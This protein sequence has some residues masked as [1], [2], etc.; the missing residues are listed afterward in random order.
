MT[1]PHKNTPQLICIA[2]GPGS[3]KSYFY[4]SLKSRGEIPTD[5]VIHDPDLIMEAMP[6]YQKDAK[7]DPAKAFERW[8]LPARQRANEILIEA[9]NARYTIVY[10]RSFALP[11]SLEFIQHAKQLGY[12]IT[13]NIL[14]CDL[15]TAIRRVKNRER[16]LSIET[17]VQRHEAVEVILPELMR[18]ADKYYFYENNIDNSEPVLIEFH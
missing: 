7:H 5:A 17:L 12:E 10:I 2:G 8:E 9:L 3:G 11:D 16:Y 18:I 4:E 15:H 6:E 1:K 14:F 13:M